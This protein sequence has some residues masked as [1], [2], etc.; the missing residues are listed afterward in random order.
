M[1]ISSIF[2]DEG[3][4]LS[5]HLAIEVYRFNSEP[6]QRYKWIIKYIHCIKGHFDKTKDLSTSLMRHF[7]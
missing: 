1:K 2:Y 7:I 3:I 4:Y 6:I 5:N